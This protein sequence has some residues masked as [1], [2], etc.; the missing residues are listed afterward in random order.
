MNIL[1]LKKWMYEKIIK[2]KRSGTTT[3]C[4][5]DEVKLKF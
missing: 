4:R 1:T 2:E 5:G 3:L